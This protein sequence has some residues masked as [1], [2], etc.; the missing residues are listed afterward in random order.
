MIV[1]R[2]YE[3]AANVSRD[4]NQLLEAAELLDKAW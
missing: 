3:Q 4:A 1:Y 2:N